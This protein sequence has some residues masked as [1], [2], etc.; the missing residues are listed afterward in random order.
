[1]RGLEFERLLVDY[2][3]LQNALDQRRIASIMH[4]KGVLTRKRAAV[5]YKHHRIY[6]G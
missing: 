2:Q 4:Y 6:S 3:Y 5:S 1:M